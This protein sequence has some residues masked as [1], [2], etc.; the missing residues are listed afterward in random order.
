MIVPGQSQK[1][2]QL[3]YILWLWP[4]T[5]SFYFLSISF[6]SPYIDNMAKVMNFLFGQ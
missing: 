5:L 2:S 4:Q 6:H 1:S 3:L